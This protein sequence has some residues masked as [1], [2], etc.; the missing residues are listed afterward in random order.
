MTYVAS[1]KTHCCCV[2]SHQL[3]DLIIP[4]EHL[5]KVFDCDLEVTQLHVIASLQSNLLKWTHGVSVQEETWYSGAHCVYQAGKR[6]NLKQYSL[7][8]RES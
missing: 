8:I 2:A 5:S 6:L 7:D 1:D 4:I 3:C